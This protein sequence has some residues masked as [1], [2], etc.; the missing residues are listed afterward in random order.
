L[1]LRQRLRCH[2]LSDREFQRSGFTG[3]EW[4]GMATVGSWELRFC[5]TDELAISFTIPRAGEAGYDWRYFDQAG[6]ALVSGRS[7]GGICE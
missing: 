5:G 6:K 2:A 1:F 4:L 7:L 3:C